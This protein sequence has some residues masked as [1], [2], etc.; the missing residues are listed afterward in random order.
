MPQA[1]SKRRGPAT[2]SAAPPCSFAHPRR[3]ARDCRA[4]TL[5]VEAGAWG[6][7]FFPC[8]GSG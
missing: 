7:T 1:G 4:R 8:R 3:E 2:P 6:P 5:T